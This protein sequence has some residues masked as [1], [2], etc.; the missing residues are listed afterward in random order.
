MEYI[1]TH[2]I[3]RVWGMPLQRHRESHANTGKLCH[4]QASDQTAAVVR[5]ACVKGSNRTVEVV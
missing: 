2:P 4:C 3:A 1:H 5:A